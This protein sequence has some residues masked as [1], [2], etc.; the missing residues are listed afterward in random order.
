MRGYS[1]ASGVWPAPPA[2]LSSQAT[3]SGTRRCG[4]NR[5]RWRKC[6]H[7]SGQVLAQLALEPPRCAA[8]YSPQIQERSQ[9]RPARPPRNQ[10]GTTLWLLAFVPATLV[11]TASIFPALHLAAGPR[12]LTCDASSPPERR[13]APPCG[14]QRRPAAPRREPKTCACSALHPESVPANHVAI[15]D[16]RGDLLVSGPSC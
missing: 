8:P 3:S 16:Q 7:V 11:V 10:R 6:T 15:G 5:H 1:P 13:S 12:S 9:Q 2:G 14:D 4:R